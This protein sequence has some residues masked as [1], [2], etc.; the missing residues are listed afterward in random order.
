MIVEPFYFQITTVDDKMIY[1]NLKDFYWHKTLE[2]QM[3]PTIILFL[4]RKN[5]EFI[6]QQGI[7]QLV[8]DRDIKLV[9]RLYELRD[10][11]NLQVP[12]QS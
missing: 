11:K 10:E 4:K 12:K 6:D 9:N 1:L 3:L 8:M 5:L 7:T 2:R